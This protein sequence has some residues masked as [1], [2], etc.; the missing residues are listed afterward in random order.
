MPVYF[1]S[2]SFVL[3]RNL[4]FIVAFAS[5][6]F[7]TFAYMRAQRFDATTFCLS[8]FPLLFSATFHLRFSRFDERSAACAADRG[9]AKIQTHLPDINIQAKKKYHF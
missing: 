2:R 3:S 7:I 9:R 1:L 4:P 6:L 8:T 5:V